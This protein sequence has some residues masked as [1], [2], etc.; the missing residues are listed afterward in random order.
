MENN[1]FSF[2]NIKLPP[3]LPTHSPPL[4]PPPSS[5][6]PEKPATPTIL[7]SFDSLG[8]NK[9]FEDLKFC[10]CCL[11]Q[12]LDRIKSK[13]FYNDQFLKFSN[14]PYP[15]TTN[16]HSHN[17][18]HQSPAPNKQSS[19]KRKF[20][21]PN[22]QPCQKQS[23]PKN[24]LPT[25]QTFRNKFYNNP[26]PL[27]SAQNPGF[28]SLAQ[29]NITQNTTQIN[30]ENIKQLN[31][32]SLSYPGI[33]QKK[34]P[35]SDLPNNKG[36]TKSHFNTTNTPDFFIDL[37]LPV[38]INQTFS[39]SISTN[40]GTSTSRTKFGKKYRGYE[41]EHHEP[42]LPT[43]KNSQF[44][45]NTSNPEPNC[46]ENIDNIENKI[47][48][49][50]TPFTNEDM[51]SQ[52][53]KDADNLQQCLWQ[54]CTEKFDSI[55]DLLLHLY[56]LHLKELENNKPNSPLHNQSTSSKDSLNTINSKSIL[57]MILKIV[58]S[59]GDVSVMNTT[60][61]SKNNT[62]P[63]ETNTNNSNKGMLAE[64]NV[65]CSSNFTESKERDSETGSDEEIQCK[66]T[67]CSESNTNTIDLIQHVL[68]KH[69]KKQLYMCLWENCCA[70]CIS[71]ELLSEHIDDQHIGSGQR[72]YY[73]GW[74]GCE[75][76]LKPFLQ[77][78]R[79]I[80]HVQIHTGYKPYICESCN[81]RFLE[82]HI[83]NQHER[84]HTGE[85]PYK[86]SI[87]NCKKTFNS[88]SA[89]KI[90]IRT[91]TGEK[92]YKCTYKD[93]TKRFAESSN[94]LKHLR[95]HTGERPFVCKIV[96]CT[97]SFSR[98]DM[99]NRHIKTHNK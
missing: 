72:E 92:P 58:S 80:R 61:K 35:V 32:K 7:P 81:K 96:N 39:D 34:N 8:F 41:Y 1:P 62:Y 3:L 36:N 67:K 71:L 83:K 52:D 28:S 30:P 19:H 23:P 48:N 21:L 6:P 93:C 64:R 63:H 37:K 24:K 43:L 94:L 66:W 9:S 84:I 46:N 33:F 15:Q 91:H 54:K 44:I 68:K 79:I 31:H 10:C 13:A 22:H 59:A 27:D 12:F 5:Q 25:K 60:E 86:C 11:Q 14:P 18:I 76:K 82:V 55:E 88:S 49:Q 57:N 29:N 47:N 89:L 73:C 65:V 20:D 95:I 78:Q 74:R 40:S 17:H 85:K 77:R 98:P 45:N 16:P 90:H 75:R 51:S 4:P 97:K 2:G 50:N 56:Q 42:Q 87:S 53:H 99:L 70:Q 69:I 26:S 38:S